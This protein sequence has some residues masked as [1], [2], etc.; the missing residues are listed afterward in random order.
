MRPIKLIMCAF[1]PYAGLA[2]EIEFDKF[3]EKGLFLITG[4]TGA[5][6]TMIFDAICFALYGTTSGEYRDTKNLRSEYADSKVKCYVEFHFSH[7]GKAYYVR[8]YAPNEKL[9][10]KEDF[11]VALYENGI[12]IAIRVQ[13]VDDAIKRLLHIDAKQF[14]QIAMIAQGEFRK[15]LNANANTRTEILRTIF[16]TD[17]YAAVASKMKDRVDDSTKKRYKIADSII[18]YFGD[19]LADENDELNEKLQELQD[20]AKNTSSV[21]NLDDIIDVTSK[22]IES[23]H[24]RLTELQA[25]LL[26]EQKCLNENS[27]ALSVATTNNEFINRLAKLQQEKAALDEKKPDIE[28]ITKLLVMQKNA[29]RNINPVYVAWNSKCKDYAENEHKIADFKGKLDAA[30]VA[31]KNA[32]DEADAA[33][34]K[35]V[36]AEDLLKKVQKITEEQPKYQQRD[37]AK[38]NAVQ[39]AKEILEIEMQEK[40]LTKEE[41][42]LK[43]QIVELKNTI[44]TLKGRPAELEVAKGEKTK[45]DELLRKITEIINN[46]IPVVV[47]RKKELAIEQNRFIVARDNYEL[48]NATRINAER[49]IE[50]CRAG[51]LAE[52]LLDGQKCPVCGSIHH[53][54]LAELP[55][56]SV[57]EEEFNKIKADE[58][59]KLSI[60]ND[61]FTKVE[62][63][64]ATLEQIEDHLKNDI[65][66]CLNETSDKEID[67]LITLISAAQADTQEQLLKKQ[68]IINHLEKDCVV[69]AEAEKKLEQDQERELTQINIK[70]QKLSENKQEKEIIRIEAEQQLKVLA[71]LSYCDWATASEQR[72]IINNKA[73]QIM[74]AIGKA[75][76]KKQEAQSDVTRISSALNTLSDSLEII[77][78]AMDKC[79]SDFD[80]CLVSQKMNSMEEFLSYLCTEEQIAAVDKEINEYDKTVDVNA[81]QLVQAEKDAEG[82]SYINLDE[83]QQKY[84]DNKKTVELIRENINGIEFRIKSNEGK[85]KNIV[86]QRSVYEDVMKEYNNCTRLYKLVAGQISGGKISLEQYVQMAGFDRIIKAAN[87]RL[88][89]MSDGQFELYRQEDMVVDKRKNN[90]LALVVQ[91]NHTG[92]RRPVGDISGGESFK[93]SLSL[94]LGLSDTV[95]SSMGG[96]QMDA[97]F[98]DEGFGT[99]DKKSIENAM[100]ILNNLSGAH[101]LV[102]I[103]SHREELVE[104][105]P[106]QINVKRTEKGSTF[107]ITTGV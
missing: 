6:K 57:S 53:P 5:G 105:I 63:N 12:P 101:K 98:I 46:K 74:D 92:R 89:P 83:L 99:L 66:D 104:N 100:E 21:W 15:L 25:K 85:L 7:Q 73:K 32:S 23:D 13:E 88:Y 29:T 70:K 80:A 50:N 45:L 71:E 97:L 93:A 47:A 2:P 91:D 72:D 84:E 95:S 22:I 77:K 82:I 75:N 55:T 107:E 65:L 4:E 60:K 38:Q 26:T 42:A 54:E 106:Q 102:G 33:E 78:V 11:E 68:D 34:K 31:V 40:A 61:V 43:Q 87:R 28:R 1:G 44:A 86:A 96:I 20:N 18:Q 35:R 52:H 64:K 49:I 59:E 69:L 27:K 19:V 90:T 8:R 56:E 58:E 51:I 103:I 16:G 14:N 3:K 24:Y 67:T 37:Q 79:R 30:N 76:A 48:A 81:K 36:E 39:L 10:K 41:D 17:G 62:Q 94:A 9:G